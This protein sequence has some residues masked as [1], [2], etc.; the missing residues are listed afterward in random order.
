MAAA[1]RLI[2][3][4]DC[5]DEP[6]RNGAG[7][8]RT[9]WSGEGARISVASLERDAPFSAYPGFDRTFCLL[10][11]QAV[12]LIVDGAA[13]VLA[14]GAWTSFA[15][16]AEVV[17]R[18]DAGPVRAANVMTERG[19][20]QH[21]VQR[22]AGPVDGAMLVALAADGPRYD[23]GDLILPPHPAGLAGSFLAVRIS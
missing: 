22:A 9:L 19:L 15:G 21:T 12:T 1:L 18:L 3:A 17:A 20:A 4:H 16:E 23:C 13:R 10:G 14:P 6:W 5:A 11:P 7:R 2:R 8:T